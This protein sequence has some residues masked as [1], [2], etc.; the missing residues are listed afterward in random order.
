MLMINDILSAYLD[1][2]VLIFL[3]D[4]LIYSEIVEEHAENLGK[5]I[6]ALCQHQLYAKMSK[7]IILVEG[8]EF[9][10]QWVT[11]H[12]A[13]P[14]KEKMKAVV[15]WETPQNVKDVRSF[16]GLSNYYHHF[17]PKDA[18]L[19]APLTYLTKKEVQ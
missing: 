6:E 1:V 4:I 7:C 10:G 11:L 19:A 13:A 16:M 17:V 5:V 15:E 9:L 3:D 14:I 2:L 12:G 18:E 8:V